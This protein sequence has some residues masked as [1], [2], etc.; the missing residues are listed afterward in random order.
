MKAKKD[1]VDA[2]NKERDCHGEVERF[3]PLD[4]IRR[5]VHALVSRIGRRVEAA[6]EA[7]FAAL[8]K[9]WEEGEYEPENPIHRMRAQFYIWLFSV[10]RRWRSH[11]PVRSWLLPVGLAFGGVVLAKFIH[12]AALQIVVAAVLIS[13]RAGGLRSG[14]LTTLLVLGVLVLATRGALHTA[15][16]PA[17]VVALT[18]FLAVSLLACFLVDSLESA[19]QEVEAERD[20]AHADA[21]RFRFLAEASAM[22]ETEFTYEGVLSSVT[23]AIVPACANWAVADVFQDGRLERVALAHEDEAIAVLLNQAQRRRSL[24]IGPDHPLHEALFTRRMVGF[25]DPADGDLGPLQLDGAN[26][27]GLRPAHVLF[28]PLCARHRLLGA[29]TLV[30]TRADRPFTATDQYIA[31]DLALRVATALDNVRHYQSALDEAA[32]TARRE[33]AVSDEKSHLERERV[34]LQAANARLEIEATTD[35]L[36]GL[37]NHLTFKRSLD[38]ELAHARMT[39]APLSVALLDVDRFKSYND[40]YGHPAGDEVLRAV[41]AVMRENTRAADLVARYGGEEFV[42]VM[43]AT[44][45]IGALETME[46]LR[47]AIEAFGWPKR[48]VTASLGVATVAGAS[49]SARDLVAAADSALYHS[50][51]SG[52]NRVMH[53]D[54]GAA[55]IVYRS[56]GRAR[57]ER[58]A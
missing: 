40:S 3:S 16:A 45:R 54:R 49:S 21:R 53:A 47:A 35:G 12:V 2:V 7:R 1:Q 5:G 15:A 29:L 19:R 43:P 48:P 20:T 52:R 14:L 27:P 4:Q 37:L 57:E 11:M 46:R 24:S 23:R 51:Q 36:T 33:R 10:G 17:T 34:A 22:L 42:V 9:R 39:G 31:R 32:E 56:A 38:R 41:A 26:A 25:A 50:K 13:V 44:D 30:S 8:R 55:A 58:M 18:A 6:A 28:V